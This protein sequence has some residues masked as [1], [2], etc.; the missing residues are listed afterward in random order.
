[1]I[2]G[3]KG[4]TSLNILQLAYMYVFPPQIIFL[5]LFSNMNDAWVYFS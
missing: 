1:M 2:K 4:V 3:L 5:Y